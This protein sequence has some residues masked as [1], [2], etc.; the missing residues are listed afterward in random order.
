MR[1][2]TDGGGADS[3]FTAGPREWE[4]PT[5]PAIPVTC[6]SSFP[7]VN[8]SVRSK[9]ECALTKH[10]QHVSTVGKTEIYSHLPSPSSQQGGGPHAQVAVAQSLVCPSQTVIAFDQ[11]CLQGRSMRKGHVSGAEGNCLRRSEERALGTERCEA[12][13]RRR[14]RGTGFSAPVM[15]L[16][17]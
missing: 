11:G 5:P 3:G 10:P 17:E 9:F 1:R 6:G 12:A 8:E 15:L 16:R 2:L 4:G 13:G 14:A 7:R